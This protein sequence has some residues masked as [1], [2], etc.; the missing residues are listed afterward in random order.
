MVDFD[1]GTGNVGVQLRLQGKYDLDDVA[2]KRCTVEQALVQGPGRLHVLLGR[3]GPTALDGSSTATVAEL[4]RTLRTAVNGGRFDVVVFDT[5]AGLN[6]STVAVAERCD[7]TLGVTTPE[8]T[9]L[10]D[11]YALAKLL[12]MR[13][14]RMPKL[15]VNRARSR[16]EA[17]R[18]A[19]KLNTVTEKFLQQRTELAGWI[20]ADAQ[21][22]QSVR[23][24][25]PLT[26]FGQSQGLE[27]LRSVCAAALADLPPLTRQR[28]ATQAVRRIRLRPAA[29]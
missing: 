9:A 6:P 21:I 8:V 18:T 27:D 13:G 4:L 7:L 11:A 12:H 1:P 23:D 19:S 14:L 2:A 25:R 5:G 10:T 26:L 24:Q 17:L 16:D 22:E 29:R 20:G 15:V 3:S 28:P